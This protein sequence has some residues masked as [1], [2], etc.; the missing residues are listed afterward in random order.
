MGQSPEGTTE[1]MSRT[2]VVGVE[3]RAS[4]VPSGRKSIRL[5]PGVETPGYFQT[6]LRDKGKGIEKYA[7]H[8]QRAE[9]E[10]TPQVHHCH[11]PVRG[12]KNPRCFSVTDIPSFSITASM[13]SQT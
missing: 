9:R 11:Y 8:P 10:K 12:R 5:P 3:S 13:S 6:S 1:G 4:T 2:L 7:N